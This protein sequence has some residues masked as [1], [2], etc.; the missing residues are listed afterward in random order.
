MSRNKKPAKTRIRR[1]VAVALTALTASTLLIVSNLEWYATP[2]RTS[3]GSNMTISVT[4]QDIYPWLSAVALASIAAGLYL[5]VATVLT[6]RMVASV[7]G[8][9]ATVTATALLMTPQDLGEAMTRAYSATSGVHN[10][11]EAP[12][13]TAFH[14][15][16]VGLLFVLAATAV[17]VCA[18]AS[19]W[20]SGGKRYVT[21]K[22]TPERESSEQYDHTD[23]WDEQ[24]RHNSPRK[25]T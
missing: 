16:S 7:L 9:A 17:A 5:S 15:V 23:A 20:G 14:I 22:A 25:E 13:S 1:G 12:Q 2:I 4:G 6:A 10:A 3:L 11:V 18:S 24:T 8:V 21:P 19:Q